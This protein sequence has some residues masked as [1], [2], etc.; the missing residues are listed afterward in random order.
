MKYQICDK[1]GSRLGK[2][3]G[4][5]MVPF[6]YPRYQRDK[7]TGMPRLPYGFRWV[8]PSEVLTDSDLTEYVMAEKWVKTIRTG[9]LCG[10]RKTYIRRK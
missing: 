5:E 8:Q 2:L 4:E 3:I 1:C 7:R 10:A 9:D 6:E